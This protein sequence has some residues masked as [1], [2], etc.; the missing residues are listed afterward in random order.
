MDKKEFLHQIGNE[1]ASLWGGSCYDFQINQKE[2]KVVFDCIEHGEKFSTSL[3]FSEIKE[4]YGMDLSKQ[5]REQ[6]R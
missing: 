3:S 4:Q 5:Q 2:K 6:E 1:V